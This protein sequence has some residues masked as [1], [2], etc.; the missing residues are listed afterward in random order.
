MDSVAELKFD[1]ALKQVSQ[2][3]PRQ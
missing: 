1:A 3:E 2:F